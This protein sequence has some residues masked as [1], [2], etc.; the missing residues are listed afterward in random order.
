MLVQLAEAEAI[1]FVEMLVTAIELTCEAGSLDEQIDAQM[2][3]L[4]MYGKK[5]EGRQI[6][7]ME[8]AKFSDAY[9]EAARRL[10]REELIA[11]WND[12]YD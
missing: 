9:A 12:A 2:L 3:V 4:T 8:D 6:D 7:W 10:G 11:A 1:S 5:I